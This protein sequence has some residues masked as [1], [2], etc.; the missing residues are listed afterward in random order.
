M[1]ESGHIPA[2]VVRI[3]GWGKPAQPVR[4]PENTVRFP[5]N[6][7]RFLKNRVRKEGKR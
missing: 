2:P 3:A 4:F 6:I 5:E 7:M 1:G